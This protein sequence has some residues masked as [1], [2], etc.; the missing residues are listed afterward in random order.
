MDI[1]HYSF[2]ITKFDVGHLVQF[3]KARL[4]YLKSS[5]INYYKN[6]KKNS[7]LMEINK[8]Y[9]FLLLVVLTSIDS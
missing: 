9:L 5:T 4:G 2:F 1:W 6:L 3:T 7:A 8:T